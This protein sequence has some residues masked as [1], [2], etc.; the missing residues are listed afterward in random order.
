MK[1]MERQSLYWDDFE[2][3]IPE[4]I[5]AVLTGTNPPIRRVAVFITEKCNFRCKYCNHPKTP[6]T[7]TE[8]TF[9]NVIEKYGDSAIIHITG[10]EPSVVPWL[11]PLL[12]ETGQ[13]YRFH[14]NT[15]AYITPP[16]EAVKRL[17]ISLD[18]YQ[19]AQW[20][21]LVGRS[22]AFNRVVKN[23]KAASEKTV[24]SITYTLTKENYDN[25]AAFVR[26]SN[27]KF[28]SL[29]AIFFSIYKGDNPEFTMSSS[30][31]DRIFNEIFPVFYRELNTE[32]LALLKETAD[33][34]RRL[35]QGIRFPQ[36]TSGPCYIS[37]SERVFS[38]SGEEYTCSHLYRDKIKSNVPVT[39]EKCLYGCNRR[40]VLFNEQVRDGLILRQL[41]GSYVLQT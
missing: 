40:L 28:P 41:G 3:R 23:I 38:P 8:E 29:Y 17:K 20:D 15:N 18:N 14:L 21:C 34:K 9:K 4:T 37:M 19:S 7:M 5:E 11:Y 2:K 25:A 32:S 16:A 36:N 13:R 26:F 10:G 30:D 22:G 1:T 35:L 12:R 6:T 24:T 33:E 31:V 27:R 39:N